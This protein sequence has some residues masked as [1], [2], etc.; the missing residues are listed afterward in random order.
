MKRL[1]I[2]VVGIIGEDVV[3]RTVEVYR[4]KKKLQGKISRE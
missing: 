4:G 1:G 2:F 3:N